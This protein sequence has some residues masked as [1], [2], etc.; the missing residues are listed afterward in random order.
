MK[1]QDL[2]INRSWLRYRYLMPLA[3]TLLAAMIFTVSAR[4]QGKAMSHSSIT[5]TGG[6]A[7]QAFR[8]AAQKGQYVFADLQASWCGPCK[9][10]K[11]RVFTDKKVADFFNTHFVN[12]SV[13]IEQGEGPGLAKKWKVEKL[14]TLLILDAKGNIVK[15]SEGYIDAEHLLAWAKEAVPAEH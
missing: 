1:Y 12:L 7:K 4:G 9:A 14:P 10:L 3:L 13:D 11:A 15:K 5:F 2:K 6:K 8:Q